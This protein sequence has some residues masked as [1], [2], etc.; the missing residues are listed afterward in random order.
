MN[1]QGFS[2]ATAAQSR[3]DWQIAERLYRERL[4][5]GEPADALILSNFAYVLRR[6]G[7]SEEAQDVYRQAVELPDAPPETWFN[8]GNLLYDRGEWTRAEQAYAHAHTLSGG[9][10]GAALQLARCAVKL[11]RMQQ[12][13]DRFAEVLRHNP[14]NFSAWLEAGNVCRRHGTREQMLRCYRRAAEVAADRWEAHVSL[15]T[16]LEAVDRRDEAAP[17]VYRA[18]RLASP[19]ARLEVYRTLGKKRLDAGDVAGAVEVLSHAST[20]APEDDDILITLGDSLLRAGDAAAAE[21]LFMRAANSS[22][23]GTRARLA[24]VMFRHNLVA[25]AEQLLRRNIEQNPD[26]WAAHYNLA[27]L[28]V[29]SWHMEDGLALLERAEALAPTEIKQSRAMRASAAGRMGDI[30]QCL[31]LYRE[32]GAEE[33]PESAY[34][35]SAAMSSL[36]SETMTPSEVTELHRSLFA[37]LG[38]GTRKEFPR[39]RSPGRRLRIG[40]VTAD[41]HHQHPVN[42]F[43]QPV[44]ARHNPQQFEITVYFVGVAIDE[45]SRLAMSRVHRWREVGTLSDL[46][47]A[48]VIN[49]D[50][51]DILVDLLGH[52]SYNRRVLFGR[53]AAPVQT[54]FL[55]YPSTTGIP[56]MDWLIADAA[57]APLQNAHLFTEQIARLPH[58]VFCYAP[59]TDY[60]FP[61]FGHEHAMRPLTFGSFNNISKLTPGTVHL[62]ARVLA[63]VPEARMIL[64]AP[65]FTD[66]G[67]V[68]RFMQ[69]FQE[70]GIAP[71]RLEFRGPVG[72][73]DMMAEYADVDI[74]LDTFPYNGGTTTWQA[75]WMGAPVI[76]LCGETFVQ[77]MGASILSSINRLEWI[78]TDTDG[79]VAAAANLASDRQRLLKEKQGL[80]E[81]I[82][83]SPASDIDSYTRNLERLYHN[84][85]SQWCSNQ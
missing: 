36:Y 2:E 52:T 42:L 12:A 39:E 8:F 16:A 75:L 43:M 28:L 78:A 53:R 14:G 15:A 26:D 79:F 4:T 61:A 13:R 41:L 35:S 6:T 9:M 46:A 65:S 31:L 1:N 25:E 23:A 74:A 11:G 19:T 10:E 62:W 80:R 73:Y 51:I 57:V 5:A 81:L 48:E 18:L 67:A 29:D 72:L 64:K 55:G 49:E 38:V 33:G 40:Y 27:K 82:R 37:P 17:H 71:E 20:V 34:L 59:E 76:T 63:A 69:L 24:D 84:M 3:Q 85:W 47:L 50:G 54:S 44:L 60:P 66:A 77:R 21:Q 30:G 22:D 32:I 45:Q 7:K 83:R 70:A 58:C 56:N 68:R